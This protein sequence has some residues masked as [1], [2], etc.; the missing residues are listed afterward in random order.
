[1]PDSRHSFLSMFQWF[2]R[3]KEPTAP[4]PSLPSKGWMEARKYL[5]GIR[6]LQHKKFQP[7]S[8]DAIMAQTDQWKRHFAAIA[9]FAEAERDHL[10]NLFMD[11]YG[12]VLTAID[13]IHATGLLPQELAHLLWWQYDH[14]L[15][16]LTERLS[17][18]ANH[19]DYL[20]R[21]EMHAQPL[22]DCF[23]SLAEEQLLKGLA[24]QLKKD[25]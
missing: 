13:R 14:A 20:V 24:A 1:M 11:A 23:L 15:E 21:L 2:K 8:N 6:Y 18:L 7:L 25:A 17:P 12:L 22:L 3:K 19:H 9:P 10:E 5:Q 16:F 4:Q